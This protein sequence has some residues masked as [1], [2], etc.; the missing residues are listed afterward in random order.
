MCR[1]LLDLRA[2]AF[3]TPSLFL[4]ASADVTRRWRHPRHRRSRRRF[5]HSVTLVTP[6]GWCALR[7]AARVDDSAGV[8]E[9]KTGA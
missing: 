9:K 8:A 2:R 1:R 6:V 7:V 3:F 5:P 4:A